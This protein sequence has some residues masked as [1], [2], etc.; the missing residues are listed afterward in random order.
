MRGRSSR[1]LRQIAREITPPILLRGLRRLVT[2]PGP[3]SGTQE[4]GDWGVRDAEWYDR[5]YEQPL[6]Y[7]KHYSQSRYYFLWTVVADRILRSG[8]RSVLDLGCGPGQFATLLRDKGIKE[9][10][11][12]DFS[13]R[14]IAIAS[15]ACPEFEFVVEDA[16]STRHLSNVSYDAVT[17]LEFLE[18]VEMDREI[19]QRIPLGTT[20]YGTVPNFPYTSHV[21]HFRNCDEVGARY[22]EFLTDF[23]V[24]SF[25]GNPEGTTYFLFQGV[26]FGAMRP[27]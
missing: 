20:F 14:S 23:E 4:G 11:G 24:E 7:L 5:I 1:F 12:L 17:A 16:L 9:Y 6:D 19:L 15:K 25:L 27:D 18:H 8:A 2:L 13:P 26:R 22:R 21:R 10:V 3:D